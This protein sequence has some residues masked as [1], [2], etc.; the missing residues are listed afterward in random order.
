M[1]DGTVE[2]VDTQSQTKKRGPYNQYLTEPQIKIPR[3]TLKRWPENISTFSKV[4]DTSNSE[5]ATIHLDAAEEQQV[6]YNYDHTSV[7][8]YERDGVLPSLNTEEVVTDLPIQLFP[9]DYEELRASADEFTGENNDDL[10]NSQKQTEKTIDPLI[11]DE[12]EQYD[13]KEQ[14]VH[15]IDELEENTENSTSDTESC[16]SDSLLY[17]GAQ[18]SVAVSM[19]L[20][21]TFAIRHSLSGTALVDLLTLISL[22]CALPNHCA[23]SIALLKTFFMQ[24]KN[25]IE[26]HYYCTFCMEYQG[27][28][29]DNRNEVGMRMPFSRNTAI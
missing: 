18:I 1:A 25:P 5:S 20:I 26:F 27:T 12:N 14:Y 29:K 6:Y 19:L 17:D 28:S 21:I 4:N 7:Y 13:E 24:L 16:A 9:D 11:N 23:S 2:N 15:Y 8:S 10:H 22:H 3:T